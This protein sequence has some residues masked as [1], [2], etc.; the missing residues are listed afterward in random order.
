MKKHTYAFLFSILMMTAAVQAQVQEKSD[1]AYKK[2]FQNYWELM[3]LQEQYAQVIKSII[4]NIRENSEFKLEEAFWV[5]L[6]KDM[7]K[8]E[9][10]S[11]ILQLLP[12]YRKHYTLEQLKAINKFFVS[13]TGQVYLKGQE[14]IQ[15]ENTD[16]MQQW[17]EQLANRIFTKIEQESEKRK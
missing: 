16:V 7:V 5:N 12:S 6:E 1:D 8:N 9:L 14:R 13:P 4:S 11:F 15:A 3:H 10:D 17:G 2:E